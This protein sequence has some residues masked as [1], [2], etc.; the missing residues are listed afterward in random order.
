MHAAQQ[1][2][3]GQVGGERHYMEA[4]RHLRK[5]S[6]CV[7]VCGRRTS[8]CEVYLSCGAAETPTS[9]LLKDEFDSR[10]TQG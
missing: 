8:E 3:E 6:V 5:K 7:C 9:F 4:L 1:N 2:A 10:V